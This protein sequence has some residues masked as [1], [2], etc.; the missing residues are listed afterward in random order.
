MGGGG[1][2]GEGCTQTSLGEVNASGTSEKSP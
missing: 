2:G 1:W